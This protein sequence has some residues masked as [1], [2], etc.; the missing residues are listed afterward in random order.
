MTLSG[1]ALMCTGTSTLECE[2]GSWPEDQASQI[3]VEMS[4]ATAGSYVVSAS[5]RSANDTDASNNQGSVTIT[6]NPP[7]VEPPA[8]PPPANKPSGGGGGRLDPALLMAFG[9]ALALNFAGGR[10]TGEH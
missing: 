3:Y 1:S 10:R 6:V 7:P 4:A 2:L 9:L 8:N 5:A